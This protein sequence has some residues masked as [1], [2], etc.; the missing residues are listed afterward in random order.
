M[1][2]LC[3]SSSVFS[4]AKVKLYEAVARLSWVGLGRAL[5]IDR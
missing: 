2:A 1:I 4:E 3:T 5:P